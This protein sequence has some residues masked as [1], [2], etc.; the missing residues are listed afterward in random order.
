M[1]SIVQ[2]PMVALK[3]TVIMPGMLIH[4][5]IS[6]PANI[7]A[8]EVAMKTKQQVF[9]IAQK[10]PDAEEPDRLTAIH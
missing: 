1:E 5:D 9:L 7:K 8:V 3:N 10:N 4:F 6:N 2:L